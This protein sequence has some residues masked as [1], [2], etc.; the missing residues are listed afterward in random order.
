MRE[1][2]LIAGI[3]TVTASGAGICS[4]I[5]IM[6]GSLEDTLFIALAALC[7][8]L[9]VTVIASFAG[10]FFY[11]GETALLTLTAAGAAAKLASKLTCHPQ[12]DTALILMVLSF[13]YTVSR[14]T[15]NYTKILSLEWGI[16]AAAGFGI[17]AMIMGIIRFFLPPDPGYAFIAAA[18]IIAAAKIYFRTEK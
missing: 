7:S 3:E 6:T 13:G 4:A 2:K 17:V 8:F 16:G 9:V 12:A 10:R 1:K 11:A 15:A 18:M 14:G 5:L